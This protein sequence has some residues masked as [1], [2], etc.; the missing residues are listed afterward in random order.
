MSFPISDTLN[1]IVS[2]ILIINIF[3]KFGKLKDG[4][5]PTILGSTIS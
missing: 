5:D 1:I 2:A 3:R 4:D